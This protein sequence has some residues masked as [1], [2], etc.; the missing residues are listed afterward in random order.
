MTVSKISL[1]VLVSIFIFM[2]GVIFRYGLLHASVIDVEAD[3][4]KNS[5]KIEKVDDELSEIKSI[6]A[7]LREG[8]KNVESALDRIY[9]KLDK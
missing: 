3:V 4:S 1:G 7:E 5:E 8:Q 6:A 9:M 2:A